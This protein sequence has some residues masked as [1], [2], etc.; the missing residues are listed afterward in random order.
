[1]RL[2]Q[3]VNV[4]YRTHIRTFRLRT[5]PL[6]EGMIIRITPNNDHDITPIVLISAVDNEKRTAEADLL[7]FYQVAELPEVKSDGT[8]R[9][10]RVD[11]ET[12]SEQ[13]DGSLGPRTIS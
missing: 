5:V 8:R 6:V 10:D 11:Q 4:N 9:S 3:T 2:E 1:M 13:A 7:L 12:S